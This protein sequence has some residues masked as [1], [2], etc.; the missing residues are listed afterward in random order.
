MSNPFDALKKPKPEDLLYDEW[1]GQFSCST[2]KCNGWASVAKYF[3]KQELLVW[4]CQEG[5]VSTMEVA[6]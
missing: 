3:P 2:Y 5:H 6:E 1:G 4:K